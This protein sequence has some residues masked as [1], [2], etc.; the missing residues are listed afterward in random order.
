M[1]T[2]Q[3]RI[4]DAT[5]KIEADTALLHQIVHGDEKTEVI[6]EAGAVK[7]A[8]KCLKDIEG[9]VAIGLEA[10]GITQAQLDETLETAKSYADTA[11]DGINQM[12]S[13]IQAS[14]AI[15]FKRQNG[16]LVLEQGE[17]F[18]CASDYREWTVMPAQ[19]Q[20]TLN[21]DGH[22]ILTL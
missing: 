20:F 6:T 18:T 7:S 21:R 12:E 13:L 10:L 19:A 8:A 15:G 17:D 1:T 2:L 4:E 14:S 3:K 11:L 5:E 16:H 22:L 9:Q